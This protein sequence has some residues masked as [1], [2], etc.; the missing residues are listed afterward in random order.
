VRADVSGRF[1][2]SLDLRQ[3]TEHVSVLPALDEHAIRDTHDGDSGRVNRDTA[4]TSC[5]SKRKRWRE[6]ISLHAG[7]FLGGI[8]KGGCPVGTNQSLSIGKRK[9]VRANEPL[10]FIFH[11]VLRVR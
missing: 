4:W 5:Y 1:A 9:S 11:A 7:L 10:E 2:L 3:Q 8:L 6:A